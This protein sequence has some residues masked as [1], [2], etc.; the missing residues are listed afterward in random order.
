MKLAVAAAL[1]ATLLLPGL[2]AIASESP[3]YAV[4]NDADWCAAMLA[5]TEGPIL[6][7]EALFPDHPT[8][9]DIYA[10]RADEPEGDHSDH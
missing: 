5:P 10:E 8:Y 1:A 4:I 6:I 2:L 7:P 9:M 3:E